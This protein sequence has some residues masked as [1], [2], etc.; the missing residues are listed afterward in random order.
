MAW[1]ESHQGLREH[2]KTLMLMQKMGW[3]SDV[4]IG[5]LHRF[6]W[7]CVDYAEDGDLRKFNDGIIATAVGLDSSCGKTFVESMV[8]CGFEVGSGFI[9]REPYFRVHDWWNY[10]GK[11]LQAK[12]RQSPEKW[13]KVRDLYVMSK[14]LSLTATKNLQPNLPN[15]TKPNQLP[16]GYADSVDDFFISLQTDWFIQAKKAYPGVNL[17]TEV[18]R[19]R[20]WLISNPQKPKKQFMRFLNGWLARQ[21]RGFVNEKPVAAA[22][23]GA[24]NRPL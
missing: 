14:S 19:A 10:I 8:D 11:F 13:H 15:L 20:M 7:W 21:D 3:N 4:T 5:K 2:P 16:V 12:Y 22:V 17:K 23:R 1:I 18:E 9:D 6:W 24:S